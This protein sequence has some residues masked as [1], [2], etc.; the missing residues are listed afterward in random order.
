M[1]LLHVFVCAFGMDIKNANW[2]P[3]SVIKKVTFQVCNTFISV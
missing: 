2:K 1:V 3:I